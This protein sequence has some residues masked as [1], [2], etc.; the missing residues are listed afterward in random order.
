[1]DHGY[2]RKLE[3]MWLEMTETLKQEGEV[4]ICAF[5]ESERKHIA[6]QLDFYGIG[7]DNIEIHI[8]QTNDVWA[9]D[10]GPTFIVDQEGRLAVAKWKFNGWGTRYPFD[11]DNMVPLKIAEILGIPVFFTGLVGEGGN[12][13]VNG[14]GTVMAAKS[15]ILNDNRNP[16]VSQEEVEEIFKIYLGAKNI[17]WLPGMR[18][19]NFDQMGWSDDTDTHI[20]TIARFVN[21][22]TI[23]YSWTEDKS[24]P[25]YPMLKRNLEALQ[26]AILETGEPP[27][28]VALA[29]PKDGYYSTS[30][31]GDGGNITK[32][33]KSVRTDASYTNFLIANGAVLVP[34]YG[35]INDD[36][37]VETLTELFQDRKVIRVNSGVIAENGGEIHC[38]TQQMPE[39]R[40]EWSAKTLVAS[41]SVLISVKK[42]SCIPFSQSIS[43]SPLMLFLL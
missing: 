10:N 32:V 13:E 1:M 41:T 31:I 26:R 43:P 5:N 22:T 30:Q 11:L 36:Q 42:P 40:I 2:Q 38:V 8:I 17:I 9:R 6:R 25:V 14:R 33:G 23:V 28:L 20:D 7:Q 16:G 12:I 39:G 19:D 18:T 27:E 4:F 34:V 3:G 29:M 37:A 15:A 35:N 21:P 24:D